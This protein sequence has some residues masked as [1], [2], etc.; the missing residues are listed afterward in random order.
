MAAGTITLSLNQAEQVFF[1]F[2][3]DLNV[4]VLFLLCV[5]SVGQ[6]EKEPFMSE[7]PG[8]SLYSR[9]IGASSTPI[10]EYK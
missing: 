10:N 7:Q 2:F 3:L 4:G 1:F 9:S 6:R 5:S 8:T